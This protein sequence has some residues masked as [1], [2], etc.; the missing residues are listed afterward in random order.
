M[1]CPVTLRQPAQHRPHLD[2][3]LWPEIAERARHASLRA[4][5][6]DYGVSH[7]TIRTIVR[8]L[9]GKE[10]VAAA[11]CVPSNHAGAQQ[12]APRLR[13]PRVLAKRHTHVLS[14]PVTAPHSRD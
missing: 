9:A 4:L 8:R 7:E 14:L 10:S 2:P 13:A 6:A 3:S 5:S 11:V 1:E 12:P